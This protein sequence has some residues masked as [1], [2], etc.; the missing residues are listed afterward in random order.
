MIE[1]AYIDKHS[2]NNSFDFAMAETRSLIDVIDYLYEY[3]ADGETAIFI[4]AD[5]ETGGLMRAQSQN[6][7]NGWLYAS[8]DHTA[9]PVPLYVKNYTFKPE[10][11]GYSAEAEPQNTWV[12]DACKAI[13]KGK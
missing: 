12:F 13:I 7:F 3:A 4:T 8:Q 5:H 11:L 1:G 6:D 10:N 2:H 9:T